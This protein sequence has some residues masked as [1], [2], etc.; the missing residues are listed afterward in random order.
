M[1]PPEQSRRWEARLRALPKPTS[2]SVRTFSPKSSIS[3]QSRDASQVAEVLIDETMRDPGA[4]EI[5]YKE[6][7][8]LDGRA[9]RATRNRRPARHDVE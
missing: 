1:T 6:G 5:G 4:V 3:R 7:L 8:A 9:A 2:G